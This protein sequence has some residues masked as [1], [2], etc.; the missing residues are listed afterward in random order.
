MK[1]SWHGKKLM[2]L[3]H[4]AEPSKLWSKCTPIYP[5]EF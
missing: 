1:L 3:T 5:A 4:S 2:L